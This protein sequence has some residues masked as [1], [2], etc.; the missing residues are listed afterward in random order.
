[1]V[2]TTLGDSAHYASPA[3]LLGQLSRAPTH[4][5]TVFLAESSR[6]N[7]PGL[8]A[9]LSPWALAFFHK[10]LGGGFC[11]Y[12]KTSIYNPAIYRT[13]TSPVTLAKEPRRPHMQLSA[14]LGGEGKVLTATASQKKAQMNTSWN[15]P[16]FAIGSRPKAGQNHLFTWVSTHHWRGVCLLSLCCRPSTYLVLTVRRWPYGHYIMEMGTKC[17]DRGAQSCV[18]R[19][20]DSDKDSTWWDSR[21][22]LSWA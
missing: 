5:D 16:V 14:F 19:L 17:Q 13:M 11:G 6:A 9:Y 15:H 8:E 18:E 20:G 22:H 2:L 7:S 12:L 10:P 3:G 1:M 21:L 4:P